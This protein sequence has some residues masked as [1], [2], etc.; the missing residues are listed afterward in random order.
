MGTPFICGQETGEVLLID[1]D[2][3]PNTTPPIW[4]WTAAKAGSIQAGH[5]AW[6]RENRD[7]R[8]VRKGKQL[9]LCTN[10]VVG[11][12]NIGSNDVEF[13]FGVDGNPHAAALLPDGNVVVA[14]VGGTIRVISTDPKAS[15]SPSQP[16]IS[17]EPLLNAHGV[18]WDD[19][20]QCVW[21]LGSYLPP[22]PPAPATDPYGIVHSGPLCL[23]N[24][25]PR[26]VWTR[27]S[28]R[29]RSSPEPCPRTCESK[30]LWHQ[31]MS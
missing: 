6:F 26:T 17:D 2:C 18:V 11:L 25:D 12:V 1:S 19:A 23:E 16:T 5:A 3:D 24:P 31:E 8:Y 29:P 10:S 9:L 4:Q 27:R 21:A 28:S 13:Y 15:P 14:R 7:V 30:S 20:R 22:P